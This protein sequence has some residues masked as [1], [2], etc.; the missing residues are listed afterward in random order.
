[1]KNMKNKNAEIISIENLKN[2]PCPIVRLDGVMIDRHSTLLENMPICVLC[3]PGSQYRK[4][5]SDCLCDIQIEETAQANGFIAI[6]TDYGFKF[7]RI[8]ID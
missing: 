1:M 4:K 8:E 7:K 6:R 3:K 5:E 2:A